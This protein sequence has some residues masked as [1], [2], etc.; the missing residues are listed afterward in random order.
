MVDAL[1]I[2]RAR[3]H[4][5]VAVDEP[6]VGDQRL[7]VRNVSSIEPMRLDADV[8]FNPRGDGVRAITTR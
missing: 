6:Q 7:D 5:E 4:V 3:D 8:A 1:G 2:D